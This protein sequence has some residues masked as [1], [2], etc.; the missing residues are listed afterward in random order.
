MR[1]ACGQPELH[2]LALVS[3]GGEL[4]KLAR[5]KPSGPPTL[6]EPFLIRHRVGT[7]NTPRASSVAGPEE[8]GC[9][10]VPDN[11][12]QCQTDL[13]AAVGRQP[14]MANA[15]EGT[16]HAP[17]TGAATGPQHPGRIWPAAD[18]PAMLK[19]HLG[20][21]ERF[22]RAHHKIASATTCILNRN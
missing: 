10:Q 14:A 4:S 7:A 12:K 3:R 13:A 16:G 20:M 11:P 22:G 21:V 5:L 19:A 17:N 2:A 9:R 8:P 6:V 15:M 1:R 18:M